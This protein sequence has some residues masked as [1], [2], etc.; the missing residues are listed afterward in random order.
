MPKAASSTMS[1]ITLRIAYRLGERLYGGKNI[2]ANRVDHVAQVNSTG[3]LFSNRDRSRSF[4]F[5]TLRDPAK[6]SISRIFF[7]A[8]KRKKK[9]KDKKK[10]KSKTKHNNE[11]NTVQYEIDADDNEIIQKLKT[12]KVQHQFGIT[13]I[14][15][16]I[17]R[18]LTLL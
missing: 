9:K 10:G 7:D 14:K 15:R 12:T 5:S 8:T 3:K 2:C 4:L 1:G 18:W 13:D 11:K 6:R 17:S 16:T